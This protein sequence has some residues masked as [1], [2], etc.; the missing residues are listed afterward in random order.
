MNDLAS[1]S[2]VMHARDAMPLTTTEQVPLLQLVP[3]WI[4]NDESGIA[5]LQRIFSFRNFVEALQFANA[6][7][8][9]AEEANHHPALTIEWGKVQVAWWTHTIKGLHRNDFIMAA[10]CDALYGDPL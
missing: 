2:I 8:A 7:G 6:V 3:M 1:D 5:Q 10:R 9:K 4:V